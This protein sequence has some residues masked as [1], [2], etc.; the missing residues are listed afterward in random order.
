MS[1]ELSLCQ[2]GL[3][4]QHTNPLPRTRGHIVLASI[5]A[6]RMP[7]ARKGRIETRAISKHLR[8]RDP[9][10]ATRLHNQPESGRCV[11]E[12][13]PSLEIVR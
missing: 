1:K 12:V 4:G 7:R 8:T 11:H 5:L 9:S 10:A 6:C 13:G 3:H 2:M